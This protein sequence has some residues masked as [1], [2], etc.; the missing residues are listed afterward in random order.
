MRWLLLLSCVMSVTACGIKRPLVM[1]RD[2]P[3]YKRKHEEKLRKRQIAPEKTTPPAP[4]PT[5]P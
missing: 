1:P 5:E 2:I 4:P 3:E